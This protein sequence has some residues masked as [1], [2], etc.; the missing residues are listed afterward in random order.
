MAWLEQHPN[1]GTYQIVFRFGDL[2]FKRSRKTSD[3]RDAA[4]RVSRLE[5][6]IRLVESGRLELPANAD[7]AAFLLSDGKLAG[8][9]K[10]AERLQLGYLMERYQRRAT[11]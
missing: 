5:E 9:P 8:K 10:V 7:P 3:A 11:H 2:K 1:A 4:A 6:N